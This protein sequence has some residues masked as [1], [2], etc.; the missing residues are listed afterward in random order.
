MVVPGLAVGVIIH[1]IQQDWAGIPRVAALLHHR[2]RRELGVRQ[3]IPQVLEPG[4]GQVVL[5]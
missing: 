5:P 1:P 2:H 4:L 3:V